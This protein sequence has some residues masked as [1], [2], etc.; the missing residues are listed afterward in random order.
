MMKTLSDTYNWHQILEISP[1]LINVVRF[2]ERHVIV[3]RIPV[4][5]D[6]TPLRNL[7]NIIYDNDQLLQDYASC[8]LVVRNQHFM[9]VPPEVTSSEQ[10]QALMSEV[11]TENTDE[12]E[13]I[14]SEDVDNSCCRLL[15][16]DSNANVA[17]ALPADLLNFLRRTFSNCPIVSHL[18]AIISHRLPEVES[19][20]SLLINIEDSHT[21]LVA[22]DSG[23]LLLANTLPTGDP[24]DVAFFALKAW[25]TFNLDQESGT[26]CLRSDMNL[27]DNT[28]LMGMLKQYVAN[29]VPLPP[30][31]DKFGRKVDGGNIPLSI[32]NL[33]S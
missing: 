27:D 23:S 2:T 31:H 4:E 25:E 30:F 3:E 12:M 22:T 7:E 16:D 24:D 14:L 33:I 1:E 11:L 18:K 26:I 29:V 9:I 6:L 32:A 8:V 21:D 19:A 15:T 5:G 10:A 17:M 13:I 20:Q 28:H